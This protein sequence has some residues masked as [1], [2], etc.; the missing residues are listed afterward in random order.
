MGRVFAHLVPVPGGRALLLGND[1]YG[2]PGPGTW[3]DSQ[4]TEI[5]SVAT[6]MWTATQSLNAERAYFVALPLRDGR[7]LVTGGET[8]WDTSGYAA[9]Y[10]STKLWN[11]QTGKWSAGGLLETA[12]ARPFG[13]VLADGRVMVGAG[14]YESGEQYRDL[15]SVEI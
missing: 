10:S 12:R 6:N 15:T 13:V 11:P 3:G 7:V 8:D 4:R 1:N 2:T 9:A 14:T 5:Y